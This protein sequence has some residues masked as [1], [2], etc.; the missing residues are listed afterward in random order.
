MKK[1]VALV[2]SG[3]GSKGLA[4]IGIINE[5]EK[6]GFEISSISGTSIGAVIGGVYAMGKLPEYT[7][8]LKN[9]SKKSVWG[10]MDFTFSMEGLLKG[11]R[12]FNEMKAFIPDT[13]IERMNIPF[14]AIATDILN[15]KEVVFKSG[16]YYE[17]I[18][19]SM[20]IPTI[21]TPVKYKNTIL[22]DGGVV[23]PVPIEHVSRSD[24]DLLIVVSLYGAKSEKVIEKVSVKD[25]DSVSSKINGYINNL[26]GLINTGDKQSLGYYSLLDATTSTMVHQLAKNNIERHKPDLL[27]TIPANSASTFDFYKAEELIELGKKTTIKQLEK[28]YK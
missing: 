6:Q 11:E 8:W 3:G 26:S 24:E 2:L 27:I 4:H 15:E 19:A 9:L 10:L 18:R 22:I 5:L 25:S 21:F 28:Y 1:K 12:L 7:E 16:S 17:A 14:A 23:N 13:N 20:S